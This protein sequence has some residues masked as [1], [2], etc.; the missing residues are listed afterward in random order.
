MNVL[1]IAPIKDRCFGLLQYPPVGLGFLAS[2]GRRHGHTFV[3]LD[4]VKEKMTFSQFEEYIKIN[5]FDV[6]GINVWSNTLNSV[7]KS[8]TVIKKYHPKSVVVLG[9]PHPSALPLRT[10]EFFQDADFVI[11]GEAEMGFPKLLD[12]EELSNVEGL[13]WRKGRQ[14]IVNKSAFIDDLDECGYPSW[15]LIHPRD[16]FLAGS[17]I[18]KN[19]A[20]LSCTRGCPYSCTFCAARL[21]AGKKIRKRT[22]PHII[23][24]LVHLNTTY[25]ITT[26][27]IPDE[28][29]TFDKAYVIDFC[30]TVIER[31]FHF[32]Y[33]FPCGIRLDTLDEELLMLMRKAGF[34]REVAVGIESGSE[35]IQESIKKNLNLVMV[36]D[37]VALLNDMGFRPIGYFILGLPGETREDLDKTI[38]FAMSLKLSAAA[39]TPFLPI[40]GTEATNTLM[41]Q[42]IL[43]AEF[44]FT[45]IVTDKINVAPEGLTK[46]EM[47]SIRKRAILRFNLRWRPLMYYLKNWNNLKFGINRFLNIFMRQQN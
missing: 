25:G 7:K 9:G 23:G 32:E 45:S 30:N 20:V 12:G 38:K 3:I 27:A 2:A 19:T 42:G 28:N 6:F 1:L 29:F 40:P 21:T 10:L 47:D 31:G 24:E 37:K 17:I 4:C 16:Y 34:R 22:I 13:V 33:F 11:A 41:K 26:F 43:P 18:T 44:N 8:I 36:K 14:I 35:R 5:K 46:E 39:F 15:D